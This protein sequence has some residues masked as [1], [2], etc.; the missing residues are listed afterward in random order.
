MFLYYD[1]NKKS[2]VNPTSLYAYGDY[3]HAT[4]T[5]TEGQA[6]AYYGIG[7]GGLYLYSDIAGK[8]DSMNDARAHWTGYWS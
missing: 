2:G 4:Q 8:Y 5:V 7:Y 1:V 3:A 6:D